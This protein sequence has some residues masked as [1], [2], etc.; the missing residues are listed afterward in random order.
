M[1]D[2]QRILA[3]D[4][5]ADNLDTL[6]TYL[7]PR[8]YDVV[9]AI[10][11]E[12]AMSILNKEKIDLV[13]LDVRLP[14]IDGFEITKHIRQNEITRLLPVI[15]ITALSSSEDRIRGIE[16]GCD[17][18]IS[19]PY[20]AQ[21]VL[22]RIKMLLKLNYYRSQTN[23]KEKFDS[24]IRRT[25]DGIVVLDG[26]LKITRINDVAVK[27]L[28]VDQ[29]DMPRDFLA[30][31]LSKFSVRHKGNLSADIRNKL[32]FCDMER[33]DSGPDNRLILNLKS[34]IIRDNE[35]APSDIIIIMR[36]TTERAINEEK[37]RLAYTQLKQTRLQLLQSAK[38]ASIGTIASEIAHE[39]RSPLGA[40]L[41]GIEL[42]KEVMV[43]NKLSAKEL[44][45]ILDKV[46]DCLD[47]CVGIARSLLDFSHFAKGQ[48]EP[49]D[50]E[51]VVQKIVSFIEHDLSLNNITI[52]T[53]LSTNTPKILGDAQ[54]LQQAFLD[55]IANAKYA[56]GKL[57]GDKGGSI[58]INSNYDLNRNTLAISVTDTGVGIQSK[59]IGKIFEPFFTTKP[60]G[61]G[62]GLGLSIVKTIVEDHKG[63]ISID[64]IVGKG[65]TITITLPCC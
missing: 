28:G 6:E 12:N 61:E 44:M 13:V 45:D 19:K 29:N 7:I 1:A 64:S 63:T 35:G 9:R 51:P 53:K 50:I 47:R 58:T 42:L 49:L 54:L 36:D 23:E 3:V 31:L 25:E 55:I 39:I 15:L 5:E 32:L 33:I 11:G 52:E 40:A 38:M 24:I 59:D 8:G 27:L 57:P 34:T 2:R 21:E 20:N 48:H 37:L 56:I 16:T 18:F 4:D 22:A 10:N 65:T 60:M 41:G 14:D 43:S 30:H 17:D 26:Q 62:T 46:E